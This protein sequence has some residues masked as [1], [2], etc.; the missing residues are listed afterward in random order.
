[1]QASAPSPFW[2]LGLLLSICL[3]VGCEGEGSPPSIPTGTFTAHI[4]GGGI[5]DTLNGSAHYRTHGDSL[6]G[7]ELGAEDEPGLSIE[8]DPHSPALRTYEVVDGTL[9]SE[10]RPEGPANAVAFLAVDDARFT[11]TDGTIELTYVGPER[12]GAT[13]SLQMEGDDLEGPSDDLSVQ[14]TG[15]L[16]AHS[17]P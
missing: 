13:F 7:L 8:L 6:V 12:V 14:V 3:L 15:A 16:D 10:E 4:K 17:S 5:R 2:W 11:A 1:M 9:L